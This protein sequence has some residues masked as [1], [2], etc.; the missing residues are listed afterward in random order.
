MTLS[1]SK[2]VSVAAVTSSIGVNTHLDFS[3]YGHTNLA[4]TEAAINYLGLKNLRD[5][6]DNPNTLGPTGSWQQ[7]ANATGAKFDDFMTEGGPS[8][9]IRDLSY[10]NQL[11]SQGILNF[12]EGGNENDNAYAIGQ[13]NSIAWTANFQQQVY[14]T[15][16]ALG[17][18]VINM[19]FGSGWTSANNW[20]GDYDK[21][22]NHSAHPQYANSQ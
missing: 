12:I 16:H 19:S 7:I 22:G 14:A 8:A 10:V 18:P 15:G 4:I 20:H 1:T 21:V 3:N 9:D 6:A 13:G 17:L 2:A 11:A 5:S